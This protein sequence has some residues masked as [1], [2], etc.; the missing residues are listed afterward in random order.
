[1]DKTEVIICW[2]RDYV[3]LILKQIDIAF[4]PCEILLV[5]AK[6]AVATN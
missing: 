2:Q 4:R 6:K 5:E 3:S 1:M